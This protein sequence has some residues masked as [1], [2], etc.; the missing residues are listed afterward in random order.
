[1][2]SAIKVCL[3][4]SVVVPARPWSSTPGWVRRYVLRLGRFQVEVMITASVYSRCD[5]LKSIFLPDRPSTN[6]RLQIMIVE[7]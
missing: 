6:E 1:M 7:N 3:G 4:S 5:C 2:V